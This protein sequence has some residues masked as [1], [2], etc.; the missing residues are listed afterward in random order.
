MD[1][2][3]PTFLGGAPLQVDLGHV[4]TAVPGRPLLLKQLVHPL[5][6]AL[7]GL[8]HIKP[9]LLLDGGA[10]REFTLAAAGRRVRL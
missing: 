1:S 7:Q 10:D 4:L 8:V 5:D 3:S 6:D 9:H 2:G